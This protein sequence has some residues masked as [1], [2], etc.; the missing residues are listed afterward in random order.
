[1]TIKQ[2]FVYANLT[3]TERAMESAFDAARSGLS[4][5]QISLV[6]LAIEL[7]GAPAGIAW[8]ARFAEINHSSARGTP[9]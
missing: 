7:E 8:I 2:V 6:L 4:P 9:R 5:F 3:L 1:M